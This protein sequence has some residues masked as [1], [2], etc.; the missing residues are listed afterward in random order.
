VVFR[1]CASL[2]TSTVTAVAWT[3]NLKL[4]VARLIY[5]K[6]GLLGLWAETRSVGGDDIC[7]GRNLLELVFAAAAR[8]LGRRDV[9]GV[10]HDGH[11][12]A[13]NHGTRGIGDGASQRCERCLRPGEVAKADEQK[14]ECERLT[15]TAH[16]YSLQKAIPMAPARWWRDSFWLLRPE[17]TSG[18]TICGVLFRGGLKLDC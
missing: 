11:D 13:R 5:E 6:I 3:D 14:Q 17:Y 18:L 9:G 2:L 4:I 12:R 10:M 1:V 16:A 15:V 7:A 8:G